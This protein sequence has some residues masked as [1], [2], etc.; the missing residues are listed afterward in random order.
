[1]PTAVALEIAG[2]YPGMRRLGYA[3]G[4]DDATALARWQAVAVP[5]ERP[6]AERPSLAATPSTIAAART[7]TSSGM[8]ATGFSSAC[9]GSSGTC[10]KPPARLRPL[11]LEQRA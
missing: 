6:L 7:S 10:T 5:V 11:L 2:A 9:S 1:M 8:L 4:V 3:V